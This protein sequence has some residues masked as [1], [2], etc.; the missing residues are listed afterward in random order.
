MAMKNLQK[1]HEEQLLSIQTQNEKENQVLITRMSDQHSE[2]VRGLHKA[3]QLAVTS[4]REKMEKEREDKLRLTAT[5]HQEELHSF[6]ARLDSE[7]DSKM[8]WLE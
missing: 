5:E 3:N 1:A 6:E 2:D 4:L 8:K 7:F